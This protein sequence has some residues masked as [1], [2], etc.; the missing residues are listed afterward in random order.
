MAE[1]YVS[2]VNGTWAAKSSS[3]YKARRSRGRLHSGNDLQASNGSP[4]V[5]V[6]GSRITYVGDNPGGYD[7]YVLAVGDDGYGYRYATHGPISVSAGDY[8]PQGG[9]IGQIGRGHLHF[10]VI[11]PTSPVYNDLVAGKSVN[12]QT[13]PGQPTKTIDPAAFFGVQIGTRIAAGAQVGNP[14][15]STA[16]PEGPIDDPFGVGKFQQAR[17]PQVSVSPLG[18]TTMR[19]GR[20]QGSRVEALQQTLAAL[21]YYKG[22]IDG[23]FGSQTK[24]A[25]EQYQ[26]ATNLEVTGIADP[27]TLEYMAPTYEQMVGT[28]DQYGTATPDIP[29]TVS[30][31]PVFGPPPANPPQ[32]RVPGSPLNMETAFPRTNPDPMGGAPIP[33]S[34]PPA[35]SPLYYDPTRNEPAPSVA[36]SSPLYYDPTRNEPA[37]TRMSEGR[38]I[39]GRPVYVDENGQPYSE[40]TVTFSIDGRWHTFPSVDRQG[41]IL[42]EDQVADYVRQNGPVDPITGERFPSF[43][44][45]QEAETY[46]KQR[47]ASRLP[48]A[49]SSPLYYD[50][51]RNEPAPARVSASG[52]EPSPEALRDLERARQVTTAMRAQRA[53]RGAPTYGEDFGTGVPVASVPSEAD[54]RTALAESG[55]E[56]LLNAMLDRPSGDIGVDPGNLPIEAG[57]G[58]GVY[59]S[60]QA[61]SR[62]MAGGV[63]PGMD[64][65]RTPA[66][67]QAS[68]ASGQFLGGI[69]DISDVMRSSIT[70]AQL[71][72]TDA[73]NRLGNAFA[74]TYGRHSAPPA[75]VSTPPAVSRQSSQNA[76]HSII[77]ISDALPFSK[78]TPE[79]SGGRATRSQIFAEPDR[80]VMASSATRRSTP[81]ATPTRGPSLMARDYSAG[82]PVSR[83]SVPSP[84]EL[85]SAGAAGSAA[86]YR[87]PTPTVEWSPSADVTSM[88]PYDLAALGA[89]MAA[90]SRPQQANVPNINV[91]VSPPVAPPQP[92]FVSSRRPVDVQRTARNS[93]AARNA[94]YARTVS[95]SDRVGGRYGSASYGRTGSDGVT[96][97]TT[98]SGTGW[99]S[100]GGGERV[101][102]GGKSYT[103]NRDGRTYSRDLSGGGGGGSSKVLCT[104]YKDK[105]WLPKRI[106]IADGKDYQRRPG[107]QAQI[108]RLGYHA[109]AVPVVRWLE[110]QTMAARVAERALW[111]LIQAWAYEAAYRSGYLPK[112]TIGGK[113]ARF[114]L[115]SSAWLIGTAITAV[116][117]HTEGIA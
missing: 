81:S 80:A 52:F 53:L 12:T 59:P 109:W 47:S 94:A 79:L 95:P 20:A 55:G 36:R 25:V 54:K 33:R 100:S 73:Q 71:G 46:A 64:W 9:K 89:G 91:P 104:Y 44:T 76:I 48:P 96:R 58:G 1:Y 56:A 67:P 86:G 115:E 75:R 88:S 32:Q 114:I 40:K 106:W 28:P 13:W 69:R 19:K 70:P 63:A 37:P 15:A 43:N 18:S 26:R 92:Q 98:S 60:S 90:T 61:W 24:A 57:T 117:R 62:G 7:E 23:K 93:T 87:A 83:S 97:G 22:E 110:T 77:D 11:P 107:H 6:I 8:V 99:E 74:G 41:N 27:K 39:S 105:G 42:S 72:A 102:V 51:T 5:A 65:S 17:T 35:S 101:T 82:A 78:V 66:A 10:E 112:G 31:N 116:R 30:Y 113:A 50:P 111:P 29:A 16:I 45:R 14:A 21:G 34:R 108:M 49:R 38:T 68:A 103:R 84:S 3:P 85:A 2:P 4:A